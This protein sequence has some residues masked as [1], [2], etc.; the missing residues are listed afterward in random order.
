MRLNTAEAQNIAGVEW[1]NRII[2]T[3][4]VSQREIAGRVGISLSL[5]HQVLR[6]KDVQL[7]PELEAKIKQAVHDLLNEA[8]AETNRLLGA[9]S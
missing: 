4:K 8:Q 6:K 3:S 1:T 7:R 2:Q 5:F 9:S